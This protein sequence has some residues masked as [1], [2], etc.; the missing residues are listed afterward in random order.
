MTPT[1]AQLY[2]MAR[3]KDGDVRDL[4]RLLDAA[5]NLLNG[6]F[7]NELERSRTEAD[8]LRDLAANN[9]RDRQRAEELWALVATIHDSLEKIERHYS[10]S[11]HAQF[12]PDL[13]SKFVELLMTLHRGRKRIEAIGG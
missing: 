3:L 10:M 4:D 12:S 5:E 11:I 2:N 13:R 8:Q 7:L 9:L 6:S 1:R